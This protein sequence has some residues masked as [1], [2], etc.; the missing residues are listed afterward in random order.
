MKM[1][2]FF[3]SIL[4]VSVIVLAAGCGDFSESGDRVRISI[5]VNPQNAGTVLSSGGD[6]IGNRVEF[7]ALPNPGWEFA[8][9]GGDHDSFDNPL[10]FTLESDVN[11]TANF[12]LF[13]NDYRFTV[14]L[15]DQVTNVELK[16]GQIPGATDFYDSGTDLEA[17]PSPP[18]GVLHAWFE[19]NDRKLFWDFRNAFSSET[20]W[21]LEFENTTEETLQ[22]QWEPEIESITGTIR[23]ADQDGNVI[24]DMLQET[25]VTFQRSEISSLQI[26]YSSEEE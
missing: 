2:K 25:S 26:I 19:G 3:V 10:A 6:E 16:F 14:Q 8:G 7:L 5:T 9:W 24:S 17:P 1:N 13:R 4:F 23:L 20:I 22:L 15:S 12:A 18:P 11:L 21:E